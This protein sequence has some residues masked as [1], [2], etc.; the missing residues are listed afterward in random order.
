MR[1]SAGHGTLANP[2]ARKAAPAPKTICPRG[3]GQSNNHSRHFISDIEGVLL[4]R[5][6]HPALAGSFHLVDR[7][8]FEVAAVGLAP[9]PAISCSFFS[10]GSLGLAEDAE[11]VGDLLQLKEAATIT[12]TAR[13]FSTVDL[14]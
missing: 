9:L 10:T 8:R 3:A 5:G 13:T 6:L 11:G 7:L 14:F 4:L 1:N 12:R 2:R